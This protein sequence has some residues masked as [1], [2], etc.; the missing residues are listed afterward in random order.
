MCHK[1]IDSRNELSDAES[2]AVLPFFAILLVVLLGFAAFAVD[3]GFAYMRQAQLQSVADAEALACARTYSTCTSGGD[4]F[5]LTNP[6]GF[7]IAT[8]NSVTCPNTATQNNCVQATASTSWNTFFL[9]LFGFNTLNLSKTAI[10]GKRATGDAL[11]IR[12][13]VSMNGNHIMT[14]SGGS[15]AVGG[16]ISTTNQSG[17]DATGTGATIT[18]YNNSTNSCGSCTPSVL[19]NG[20]VLPSPPAYTPPSSPTVRT[21]P[22]CVSNVGTFLPGTYSAAVSMSCASNTLTAGT[23]YFNGGFDNNGNTL[24]GTG[25][26]IIVGVDKAFNLSGTVNLN[27]SNGSSTCGTAGGGMVVYQPVTLTNTFQSISVA[28]AGNNITLT[29]KVQL[30][31]TD[32]TFKGSPTSF[33]VTGSLYANSLTLKGNMSAGISADPCQNINLGAGTTI[34]VQ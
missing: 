25:V 18:V 19:S 20:A 16:G 33:S 2:G 32:F 27:S 11:I 15:V 5:P 30:P 23:Y 22:V 4:Q 3:F 17:I 29:G 24:T 9:P 7:T 26:T 10:A 12:G 6:Y 14:V 8:T 31:N 28:G 13:V 1:K 21:A 34:L